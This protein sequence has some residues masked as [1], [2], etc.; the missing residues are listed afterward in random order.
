M[1]SNRASKRAGLKREH[2]ARRPLRGRP[3]DDPI[4]AGLE[5]TSVHWLSGSR[6]GAIDIAVDYG[7]TF[8]PLVNCIRG[9]PHGQPEDAASHLAGGHG[10]A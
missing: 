5:S 8:G 1:N 7:L 10:C 3:D 4:E 9:M 6:P 2:R